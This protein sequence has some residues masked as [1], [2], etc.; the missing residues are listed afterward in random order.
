MD[1]NGKDR[2]YLKL[3]VEL[4]RFYTLLWQSLRPAAGEPPH[5]AATA[6]Q[7]SD[8]IRRVRSSL[9]PLLEK[10]EIVKEKLE[11]EYHDAVRIVSEH[12]KPGRK[13]AGQAALREEAGRLMNEG[14]QKAAGFSDLVALFRRL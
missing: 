11:K 4:T 9:K 12:E 13:D 3:T 10:N 7:I 8:E 2:D 6:R 1:E 5:D 14:R